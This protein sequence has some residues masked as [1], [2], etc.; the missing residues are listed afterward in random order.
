MVD[1]ITRAP[2]R[3]W[4]TIRM[5]WVVVALGLAIIAVIGRF[6]YWAIAEHRFTTVTAHQLYQSAQMPPD[7]LLRV[8]EKHGIKT[9]IDLRTFEQAEEIEEER[10]ALAD[11]EYN[12]IHLPM[13]HDPVDETVLKFLEIVGNPAN[14]PV[15]IHCH[16]GTGR[17][18]LLS[19]LFR[20]EFEN[21][22]NEAARRKVEPLHW[23]G[24]FAADAPKGQYLLSYKPHGTSVLFT[25]PDAVQ[26]P[27][28]DL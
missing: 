16:H 21:W 17:S 8:A 23:R 13:L 14:R 7:Q 19:S 27:K 24:N 1:G 22:D 18:V 3:S 4:R 12:Y 28:D 2:K 26:G 9:V 15:L 11:S 5:R 25:A 10:A 6:G 20:V